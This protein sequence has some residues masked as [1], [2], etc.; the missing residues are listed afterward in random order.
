MKEKILS[1]LTSK[2]F[3]CVVALLLAAVMTYQEIY[4]GNPEVAW[5]IG[6]IVPLAFGCLF[7]VFKLVTEVDTAYQW[8][9]VLPWIVGG[10]AG[11]GIAYIF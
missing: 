6:F 5:T 1:F 7:E 4:L 10:L 11:V 2:Y 8:K 3:Q 9:N